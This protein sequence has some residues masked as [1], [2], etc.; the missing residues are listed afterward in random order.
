[1]SDN[2]VSNNI[3]SD[4][5]NLLS[6]LIHVT[7]ELT[8]I[9]SEEIT[10]LKTNRP[11]DVEKLLPH[12]NQLMASYHKE[13]TELSVRGGLPAMGN[14][15]AI[16][17][18]KHVSR[19]FQSVLTRHTRLVKTLKQIS[20]N[21]IQAISDEVVRSQNQASRYGAD[22]TRSTNKSPTSISLNQTV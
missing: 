9:I 6:P 4:D 11:K 16:R 3:I 19:E 10:L 12:K 2:M 7:R 15:S 13:M 8:H 17:D 22:G 18:L 21:M 20:E 14:G 1:M 5:Q